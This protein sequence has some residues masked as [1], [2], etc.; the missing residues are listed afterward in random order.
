MKKLSEYKEYKLSVVVLVYNTEQYLVECFDSL[1]NQTLEDIEI[2]I[3]NDESPDNSALIIND[4]K[5]KYR[6]I[7][8]INQKNSGGAVAGNNGVMQ[9]SGKYVALV[10][11]DDIV[12]LDAYEKMYLKAEEQG[13]DIVIGKA[14]SLVNGVLRDVVYK[15]ERDVWEKERSIENLLDFPDVFYDGFYWNKIYNREF[16]IENNSLMPPG[17]LYADRP[18]VHKAFLYAKQIEIIPDTVYYWRKRESTSNQK[19]ITQMKNEVNNLKDRMESLYH[20]INYFNE[21]GNEKL[22]REFLKRNVE[23]LFFPIN[24]ILE[25]TE[26]KSVYLSEVK[27]IFQMIDDIYENDLGIVRN[28][29]IYMILNDMPN[30]LIYFLREKPSGPILEENGATIGHCLIIKIWIKTYQIHFL[31]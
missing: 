18:M 28:L 8:V 25:S 15:R 23:R 30:E 27:S 1:V 10:D 13:A 2:V 24:G 21:F 19:S 31:E 22:K 29:Y 7:K 17:M 3:V 11:S 9:A 16:L 14:E 12:P 6:N 20:Q 4:Y 26:F 5:N